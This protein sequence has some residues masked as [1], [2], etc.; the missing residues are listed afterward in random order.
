[1][2]IFKH[3]GGSM[4]DTPKG[5]TGFLYDRPTRRAKGYDLP[6]RVRF[7]LRIALKKAAKGIKSGRFRQGNQNRVYI[8]TFLY[9]ALSDPAV[10]QYARDLS[11]LELGDN[12]RWYRDEEVSG[13]LS[14]KR[15]YLRLF[16]G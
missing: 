1:M 10:E 13:L 11:A 2:G 12:V 7:Q 8:S 6:W 15:Y 9:N 4:Y 16:L 5:E 14:D 3:P